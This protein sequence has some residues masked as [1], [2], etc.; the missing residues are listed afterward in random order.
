MKRI[1]ELTIV[2][3]AILIAVGFFA[4]YAVTASAPGFREDVGSKAE[5][6]AA[7]RAARRSFVE[8]VIHST[9]PAA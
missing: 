9:L 6:T 8:Q 5:F 7:E 3:L 1:R 4:Q 2:T